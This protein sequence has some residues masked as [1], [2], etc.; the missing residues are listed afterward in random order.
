VW[1]APPLT[2]GLF[3]LAALFRAAALATLAFA[4]LTAL[5]T[6]SRLVILLV[7]ARCLLTAALL[8]FGLLSLILIS[9][10][11]HIYSSPLFLS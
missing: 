6:A 4:I 2:S 3:V 7:S 11:C 1:T 5:L 9:L 8:A 10:V